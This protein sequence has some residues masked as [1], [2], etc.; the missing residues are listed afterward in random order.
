MFAYG[1]SGTFCITNSQKLTKT[2]A[3]QANYFRQR[4]KN[5][6]LKKIVYRK[7][8]GQFVFKIFKFDATIQLLTNY[9]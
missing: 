4:R 2:D 5:A 1:I 7:L 3:N 6:K 9:F 8:F